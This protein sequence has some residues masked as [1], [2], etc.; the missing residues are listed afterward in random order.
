MECEYK[1]ISKFILWKCELEMKCFKRVSVFFV[2][3]CYRC[4]VYRMFMYTDGFFFSSI[5]LWNVI[6]N[7]ANGA[8]YLSISEFFFKISDF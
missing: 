2:K 6:L 1:K 4:G 3:N 8:F 7:A 5:N